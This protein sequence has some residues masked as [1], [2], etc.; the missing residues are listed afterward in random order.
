M[1]YPVFLV[2]ERN[3]H[4]DELFQKER[5]DNSYKKQGLRF[6]SLLRSAILHQAEKQ[7]LCP[8]GTDCFLRQQWQKEVSFCI[9]I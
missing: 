2:S 8:A 5:S 3:K 6:H 7:C 4:S 9:F 1:V